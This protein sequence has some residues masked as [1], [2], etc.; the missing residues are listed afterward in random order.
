MLCEDIFN[1]Q[2]GLVL[3]S[4]FEDMRLDLD[5]SW[6]GWG[7]L[8]RELQRSR[9]AVGFCNMKELIT[10]C[11]F[12]ILASPALLRPGLKEENLLWVQQGLGPLS[13]VAADVLPKHADSREP[14][15]PMAELCA[16]WTGTVGPSFK[17]PVI[18]KVFSVLDD[19]LQIALL[20]SVSVFSPNLHLCRWWI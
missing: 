9:T 16:G 17:H 10:S 11:F 13:I 12:D 4:C 5:S 19:V 1:Q 7:S 6:K 8:P 18:N 3:S 2:R 14:T 20:Q 15:N